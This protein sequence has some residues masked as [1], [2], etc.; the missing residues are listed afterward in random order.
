VAEYQPGA[1]YLRELPCLLG[2]LA[3]GPRA[4]VVVID[5]YVWL[6]DG[7]VG[8]GARLHSAI[9]GIVVGVAKTQFFGATDSIA[10]CR[11]TSRSPLFVSSV[12]MPTDEAGAKVAG[13]HGAYRVPTLLKAVD[14][15][16]RSATTQA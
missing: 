3:R 5:G 4:D 6:R 16:A 13:M 10:I 11:G 1:F 12:G 15:L 14:A 8:L 2:V 7:A 9:G